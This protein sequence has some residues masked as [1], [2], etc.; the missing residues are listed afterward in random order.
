LV[1]GKFDYQ[2]KLFVVQLKFK[3]MSL[4]KRNNPMWGFSP[5][6]SDFFEPDEFAFNRFWKKEWT[7][8]VNILEDDKQFEIEFAAPGMRKEDFKVKIENNVLNVSAE[9]KEEKEE[10][11]KK[12]TRQEYSYNSFSRSFTLPENVREDDVKAS[13]QDG[14]LRLNIAKKALTV[15]KAKEITVG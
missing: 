12:Y 3:A 13:Y 10:R 1:Y 9:H 8:A 4:I 6:L 14:V 2:N 7:P 5:V 11:K 15:S